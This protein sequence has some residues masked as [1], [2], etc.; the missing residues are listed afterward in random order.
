[1]P[2]AAL[3]SIHARV[4]GALPS[5]WEDPS[6]VQLWGPRF[7]AYVVAA[8]DRTIFSLGRFPMDEPGRRRAEGL[9]QRLDAFLDGRRMSYAE[10]GHALGL[11]PNAFRYAATT[12]RVLIRWEGAM[13]PTVWM[14]PVPDIDARDARAELARR[15]L[16][17]L[18]PGTAAGFARWAGVRPPAARDAFASLEPELEPVRT[19][20]GNAWILAADEASFERGGDEPAPVRLL[21]SGDAFWLLQ[22]ADRDLLVPDEAARRAL[23]TPRVWPGAVLVAGEV[24]GT[25]RRADNAVTVH[26][27]RPLS[28]AECEAVEAEAMSLPLPGLRR[29]ITVYWAG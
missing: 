10:A 3:L 29:P 18:G 28:P 26:A 27:L 16:H 21:P 1:V 24:A 23:W 4:S 12:G 14:A 17:V 20:S 13:R 19:P 15:Y 25:W 2:R 5:A 9:A 22:G 11:E 7:S 6:L 8:V